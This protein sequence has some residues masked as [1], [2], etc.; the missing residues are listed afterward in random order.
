[1]NVDSEVAAIAKQAYQLLI[2]P[3]DLLIDRGL[4]AKKIHQLF[5]KYRLSEENRRLLK[6][7]ALLIKPSSEPPSSQD[8]QELLEPI[9]YAV[10]ETLIETAAAFYHNHQNALQL[11]RQLDDNT[12]QQINSLCYKMQITPE[13]PRAR[14]KMAQI[15]IFISDKKTMTQAHRDLP[16][17]KDLKMLFPTHSLAPDLV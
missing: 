13:D 5:Q 1:M 8:F 15:L 10:A 7:A 9:C 4:I 6:F 3:H 17:L 2:N 14:L 16:T 12:L 11:M